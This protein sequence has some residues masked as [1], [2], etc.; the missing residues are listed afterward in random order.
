MPILSVIS[1]PGAL[2][3]KSFPFLLF[4]VIFII[5]YF[6]LQKTKFQKWFLLAT[7]LF[8]MYVMSSLNGLLIS[9]IVCAIVYFSAINISK[10][11]KTNKSRATLFFYIGVVTD[12]GALLFF[13]YFKV[14]YESIN[15]ILN[16]S[17]DITMLN[18][19]APIGLSYFSLSIAAYLLDVKHGKIKSETNF[20]DFL[21]YALYFPAII[22]GPFNLYKNLSPQ[23]KENHYFNAHN[24]RL[25]FERILWG[26]FLKNVIA[27][28]VGIL[29]SAILKDESAV[30]LTI[31]MGMFFYSFQLYADFAGGINVI[32]G[33]SE[34][35]GITLP[36][37]FKSPFI[38]KS[39][40]E[41]WQRWH[42][43]LGT[44]MEKYVYYPLVLGK[45]M[46]TL[47]KKI[48]ND[49]FSKVFAATAANFLVFILVGIWHGTGWN[50]VVYGLYQAFFTSMAILCKPIYVKLKSICHV[51]EESLTWKI[52][53]IMRTITLLIFG[54]LL[55]KASSLYE[56]A[57]LIKRMFST[58]NPYILFDGTLSAYMDNLR[59]Y[60]FVLIGVLILFTADILCD[61]GFKFRSWLNSKD[62]VFRYTVYILLFFVIIVFGVYGANTPYIYAQY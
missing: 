38:S 54:R 9:V 23:L 53:T 43:S 57:R 35:I 49:Y 28:R 26:Y 25:G 48:K 33:I 58:F 55:I 7:D 51:N 16:S 29:V 39:I 19:I 41:Y 10:H 13:K 3:L 42:M 62:I 17:Q 20:F 14:T 24:L 30:G 8:F 31:F 15:K 60:C 50:Y 34:I 21:S 4:V 2:S 1:E 44:I 52:F 56:A 61:C 36:E 18:I 22:E 59:E 40:T 5:T 27:D 32:M 46:R 37:N 45:T 11:R 47:S 6:L 12:L